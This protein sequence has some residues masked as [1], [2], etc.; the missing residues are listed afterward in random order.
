M[1]IITF[2]VPC[3]NSQNY[4]R[5][6]IDSILEARQNIELIIIND[7]STDD[8]G[9]IAEQYKREN[10][11]RVKVIHQ[12]N[13]GHG[14]GIMAEIQH[15]SGVFFKVVDSDDWVD[16]DNLN[17]YLLT[18]ETLVNQD[19]QLVINDYEYDYSDHTKREIIS[20]HNVFKSNK[21]QTWADSGTF[22]LNQYLTIHSCTYRTSTL[23]EC[24]MN[25]PKHTFYEDNLYIYKPLP[26]VKQFYYMN[27]VL[28][29]YYIGR[30][31]QSMEEDNMKLRC[32]H[33]IRVS[34]LIFSAYDIKEIYRREPKLGKL[35]LR[36]NVLMLT[37]ATI[38]ARLNKDKVSEEKVRVM[39]QELKEVNASLA[40]IIKY[41]SMA[42][43]VCLPGRAGRSVAI[44]NY[45]MAHKVLKFN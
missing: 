15:A 6:C 8:T 20:Y 26:F 31:G 1:K 16:K 5:T 23:R 11:N 3:Y 42:F 45:R 40:R 2:L 4:M 34:K 25:L 39:W 22:S 12:P 13:G 30:P 7:G 27:S 9:S 21:I 29:H 32:D 36:E 38:F 37:A 19:V 17:Q 33:Q 10:P 44:M 28:Y 24:G 43:W 14:A 41:R 35:M 18:L